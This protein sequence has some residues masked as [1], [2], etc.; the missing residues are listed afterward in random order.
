MEDREL[1]LETRDFR[2]MPRADGDVDGGIAALRSATDEYVRLKRE[3][4]EERTIN[5][6]LV[7]RLETAHRNAEIEQQRV[8]AV[9]ASIRRLHHALY[10]GTTYE[11]ILRASMDVSEAERGYYIAVR[12]GRLTVEA[13]VEVPAVVGESPS[14]FIAGIARQVLSTGESVHW[15]EDEPPDGV[16]PGPGELITSPGGGVGGEVSRPRCT[17]PAECGKRG[18]RGSGEC[19]AA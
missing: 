9:F 10:R 17:K 14:P 11:H 15:V 6:D 8:S 1:E 13:A 2:I 4:T 3:L 12:S 18:R 19:A 16:E 7:E 5:A